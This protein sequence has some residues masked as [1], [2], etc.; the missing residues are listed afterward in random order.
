MRELF[1][2][3]LERLGDELADMAGLACTAMEQATRALLDTDSALAEQVVSI[4]V[5][6]DQRGRRCEEHACVLLARQAPVARDLR[7]VVTAIRMSEMI[8]RMGQLAAHIAELV[9]LRHPNPV[10]P[11]ELVGLFERMAE[12]A[13]HESR[14]VEHTIAAPAGVHLPEIE[15]LDDELDQIHGEVLGQVGRTD[16]PYPVQCG[17]DVALLARYVERFADQAVSVTRQLDYV[18]TGHTHRDSPL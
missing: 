6:I 4:R 9:R 13:V 12:L 7:V 14:L 5:E 11:I 17:I 16:P 2:G 1:H 10:L 15:R 3:Q 18:A 8:G